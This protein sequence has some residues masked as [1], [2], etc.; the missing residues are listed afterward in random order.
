MHIIGHDLRLI[1]SHQRFEHHDCKPGTIL[2]LPAVHQIRRISFSQEGKALHD[3]CRKIL[4][5]EI[6][7]HLHSKDLSGFKQ[8]PVTGGIKILRGDK[9]GDCLGCIRHI[10][11]R[12]NARLLNESVGVVCAV[13][14]VIDGGS[15]TI[16]L[17]LRHRTE[18]G[19]NRITGIVCPV[20]AVNQ[21]VDFLGRPGTVFFLHRDGH[22]VAR[23]DTRRFRKTAIVD[24]QADVACVRIDTY[25]AL[26]AIRIVTVEYRH[27]GNIASASH[28]NDIPQVKSGP[29]E[30]RFGDVQ[31]R[32][33][34]FIDL[35]N[36]SINGSGFRCT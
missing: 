6:N 8:I 3:I 16:Q 27:I 25:H 19:K 15:G 4:G 23:V 10:H 33:P 17:S 30:I 31:P 2:S 7:R 11:D 18:I 14:P 36:R 5:G 9:R 20:I 1:P 22:R 28:R 21:V 35:D 26:S 13:C 34:V 29:G 24:T 32:M 12:L